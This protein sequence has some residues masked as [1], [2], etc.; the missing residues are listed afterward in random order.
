M[1][2]KRILRLL[3]SKL[4]IVAPLVLLQFMMVTAWF[5]NMSLAFEIVPVSQLLA[6]FLVIYVINREEDAGYKIAWCILISGVPFIGIPLYLLAGNRK[7]PRKIQNGTI[8]ANE[9]MET[10]LKSNHDNPRMLFR[11]GEKLGFPMYGNTAARYYPSGEAW[12]TDF[13]DDLKGAKHFIFMEFFIIDTGTCL[14][15]VLE[16]LY[17]KVKEGVEV[18]LI[19]DDFGCVTLPERVRKDMIRGGIEVHRFNRLRPAFII[20]MNNR[21]HRKFTVIDNRIGYCGGVNLADEYLNRITRFGYWKDSAMRLEGAAVWSL[22]VMFL[23]MLMYERGVDRLDFSK[24]HLPIETAPAPGYYQP[25]S[26]SPTDGETFS[27]NAHLNLIAAARKYL[28][29]DT[30]YLIPNEPVRA[31]LCLAAKNGVDVRILVPGIADKKIVNQ[32]TKANYEELVKSGVRIYEF[33]K[34]FNHAKNFVVDDRFALVGS[35]NMD[36]RSYFLHFEGGVLMED[37]P[38]IADMKQDFLQA[39]SDSREITEEELEKIKLPVRLVRAVLNMFI[40]LV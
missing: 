26:D 14:N 36:Y 11:Y 29:I 39:I 8:R 5:Y 40:P 34:G 17:Q 10:L 4:M 3:T 2:M 33:T 24:Y 16:V 6:I 27:L 18:K 7:V 30:P 32:I 28:Y 9:Q 22:T 23:G 21:D 38:V 13:L 25:F 12:F 35:V 1:G 19:Y 15:E 31:A 37:S 20:Q